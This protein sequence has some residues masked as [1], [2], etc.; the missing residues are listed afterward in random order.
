MYKSVIRSGNVDIIGH[1]TG[2]LINE[3]SEHTFNIEEVLQECKVHNVA[4]E[5]NCQPNRLDANENILKRC[6]EIGVKI[7]LGSDAHEKNQI[8]YVKSFG[9]W[10]CKR[11]WLTKNDL[12]SVQNPIGQQI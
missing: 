11:A 2:R 10:I 8:S 9:F 12:Y 3:R 1:I 7:A 6:K 4:I 5:L